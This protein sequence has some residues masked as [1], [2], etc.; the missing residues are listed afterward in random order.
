MHISSY[1]TTDTAIATGSA[2]FRVR[3]VSA[4]AVTCYR[5]S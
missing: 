4:S 1:E 2:Q 3:R 5:I